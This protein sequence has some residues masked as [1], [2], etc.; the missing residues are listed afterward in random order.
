MAEVA[1]I[2]DSVHM[3]ARN[4]EAET[5]RSALEADG[6]TPQMRAIQRRQEWAA[7]E[8]QG[9]WRPKA[10]RRNAPSASRVMTRGPVTQQDQ[11]HWGI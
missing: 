4:N 10:A 7:Q 1:P 8:A 6:A 11:A 3:A 5:V 9:R 2:D